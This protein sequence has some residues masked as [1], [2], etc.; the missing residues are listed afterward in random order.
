M[1]ISVKTRKML[2][3]KSANRCAYPTCRRELVMDETETDDPSIIG[4]E[5]HIIAREDDGPRGDRNFP[6]ERRDLYDNLILMCNIHH[7]VID[8]QEGTY[9]LGKLKEMKREHEEWVRNSLDIDEARIKSE[10]IY[11]SYIDGWSRRADLENWEAWTSSLLS[12]GQ[13][14]IGKQR[15]LELEELNNWLFTRVMP[16]T[17]IELENAF[18]NFRRV[19]QDLLNTFQ[20]HAIDRGQEFDTRKFYKIDRWDP[21]LNNKLHKEFM[22]HV[23]LVM[24]LTLELT[25]AANLICDQVRRYI[26][27]DYR[28][29]EGILIVT[30]GPY[31]DLSF[32]K[33]KVKYIGDQRRNIPY[34]NLDNFKLE[35][36]DRDF[37]FGL[38]RNVN[39][40]IELGIEY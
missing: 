33:H 23:D 40:A 4:E 25:R 1:A 15:L 2:W 6:R 21:E 30:S 35:R 29:R 27:S 24:D 19:L 22:F 7:K 34:S 37:Y 39:E 28:L 9:T 31:M 8:D 32:T 18:E 38:G 5:C 20:I 17:L 16:N 12:F 13:P 10:L 14:S 3:G 26:L 36:K 11:S